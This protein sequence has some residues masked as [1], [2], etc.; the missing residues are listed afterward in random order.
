MTFGIPTDLV[1][2]L[3]YL[4]MF[5]AATSGAS[6][7]IK[8]NADAFG[9]GV[10]AIAT[11]CAGGLCRDVLMGDLPPDNVKSWM[12]LASS[13]SGGFF[14]FFFYPHLRWFL[15]HPVQ[16]TDA[17]GLALFT[18][19][20]ADKALAFGITPIWAVLM[21]VI[22]GIGGGVVRDMLLA[23]TPTILHSEIYA[24]A[25]LAGGAIIVLCRHLSIIDRSWAMIIGAAVC[26]T[27]RCLAIKY[28]WNI[29]IKAESGRFEPPDRK[30]R[31]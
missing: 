26:A 29:N 5:V 27:I 23:N 8:K 6:A 16:I 17:F 21:G 25:S 28:R 2:I 30:S 31:R 11:A 15:K 13:L 20:G 12:P 3:N 7:G 9:I 19:L 4:A 14:A 22:T 18:A 10:L 1:D 24:T